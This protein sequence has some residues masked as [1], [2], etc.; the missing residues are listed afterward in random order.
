MNPDDTCG[1][2]CLRLEQLATKAF[3]DSPSEL[4]HQLKKKFKETSP[5]ALVVQIENAESI[6]SVTN[7]EALSWKQ[8]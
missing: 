1:I 2:Y 4:E 7:D 8:W 3:R 5:K 6:F